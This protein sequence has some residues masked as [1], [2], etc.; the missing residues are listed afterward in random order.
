MDYF[1]KGKPAGSLKGYVVDGIF[2]SDEE[3]ALYNKR[4]EEKNGEGSYYQN[5]S[6][7]AGDY[8]YRDLNGDG[9]ITSDDRRVIANPEPDFFGGWSIL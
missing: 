7:G 9:K 8:I 4:A 1:I 3:V 5:T 6:T 2:Q